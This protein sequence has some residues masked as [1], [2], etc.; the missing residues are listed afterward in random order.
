MR[1]SR[2]LP[3][4]FTFLSI[5]F[6]IALYFRL[7]SD[8]NEPPK[9]SIAASGTTASPAV[10]PVQSPGETMTLEPITPRGG[11]SG[12]SPGG[13]GSGGYLVPAVNAT[14]PPRIRVAEPQPQPRQSALSRALAPIVKALTPSDAAKPALPKPPAGKNPQPQPSVSQ[15]SQS[16]G[17]SSQSASSRSTESETSKDP[18]SDLQAPRLLAV[19][20]VPPQVH[21][22]EEAT[23]VV[24]AT[25][26]L[27]GIR[28]VSGT[29]SSPTGKALL[30]FATQREGDTNRYVGR[31]AIAKNAEE[32]IWRVSFVNMSD[33]ASNSVTLSF[34]QGGVPQNAVLRVVSSNSD[35]T[36]PTL[37]NIW[38]ERRA[39]RSGEKDIVN[40][41][42]S[43]DKSGVN[44]VSAVFQSP[45]KVARIGAGC[46][47]AEGDVWR[48]ELTIPN[49][50]DCGD[51][52]MEQVTL[53]DK[54]NN[55]ATFRLENPL[56]RDAKIN[57]SGDSCDSTAPLLQ[58]LTLDNRDI[59]VSRGA[60][61]V[62]VTVVATDDA[63]GVSGVSGQYVGP[64]TGSGGFFPLQQSGDPNTFTGR[65]LLDAHAAR[66]NWRINSIQ[67]NDKGHNLRVYN[68]SDALLAGAVFHVR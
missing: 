48:C 39:I 6:V 32:G 37:K 12:Q 67:L 56:V 46:L 11:Q 29:M 14:A 1:R 63:C 35:S 16:Q 4:F 2:F 40:V 68:A 49:C 61:S 50:V 24:T 9:T 44:L 5:A 13:A 15:G 8:M 53:Q 47:R 64:G 31:V 62:I 41:E 22:G 18:N 33:N 34:A 66:G 51:W 10:T 28:G 42:A 65:I 26:D 21:D 43:D 52:Q 57:I 38:I 25:D 58:S 59:D 54:A 17:Q 23:V 7:R 30:G 19:E 27:S 20:F 3:L 55:L 60:T 45:S 36:P